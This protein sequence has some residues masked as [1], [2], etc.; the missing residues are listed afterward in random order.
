MKKMKLL[1]LALAL[2]M[3]TGIFAGCKKN[4][5]KYVVLEENF[6]AEQYGIGF[7]VN[8]IKLGLEVQKMMDEM[9]KDGKGAEISKKWF[10]EDILSKDAKYLKPEAKASDDDKSLETV[11][12][13]GELVVGL[14]AHF[15]PMGFLEEGTDKVVG[16]DIDLAQEVCKRLGV[17]LKTQPIDWDTKELELNSGKIDCI[18]NGMSITDERVEAMYFAKPYVSNRQI[19]IVPEGSD[20]KTK[21]DFSGKNVGLQKGSSS[22]DALEKEE[23]IAKSVKEIFEY[24]DNVTAFMDLKAGRTDA[25]VVDEV[26]GKYLIAK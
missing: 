22:K 13:K 11:K 18:W 12:A 20:I 7:R 3:C 2:V 6:G 14:D 16:F 19:I 10:K 4:A 5:K 17:K 1:S 9:I 24:P 15:P 25:F 21:K 26:V 8:D 23:E